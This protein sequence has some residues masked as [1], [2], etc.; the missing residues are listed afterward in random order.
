MG[1][2]VLTEDGPSYCYRKDAFFFSF[3][4]LW[5]D[6]DFDDDVYDWG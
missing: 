5:D 2:D 3:F 6:I 4:G 1:F